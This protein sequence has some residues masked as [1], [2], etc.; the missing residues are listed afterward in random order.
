MYGKGKVSPCFI[1]HRIMKTCRGVEVIV[2]HI[3]N[4][5]A[6]ANDPIS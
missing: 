4:L 6:K 1:K 2:Q 5:S 3:L